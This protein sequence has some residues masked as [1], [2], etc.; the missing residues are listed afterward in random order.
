LLDLRTK[1]A[2]LRGRLQGN[3][4]LDEMLMEAVTD[5]EKADKLR[6]ELGLT[7]KPKGGE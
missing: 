7:G 1:L 3:D 6:A 4:K 5:S 2:D